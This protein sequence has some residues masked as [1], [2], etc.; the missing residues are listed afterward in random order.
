VPTLPAAAVM[1]QAFSRAG[2]LVAATWTSQPG[3]TP[4]PGSV[5]YRAPT[6]DGAGAIVD[7]TTAQ[8]PSSQFKGA[9]RNDL[10][11]IEVQPGEFTTFRVRELHRAGDGDELLA[12]L[13]LIT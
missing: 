9:R 8:W 12:E 10:L 2:M 3:G 7:V 6:L 13:A 5:D 11:T 4:V 1:F